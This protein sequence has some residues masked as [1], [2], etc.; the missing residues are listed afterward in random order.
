[1][2]VDHHRL[3]LR[4]NIQNARSADDGGGGIIGGIKRF[5]HFCRA[6]NGIRRQQHRSGFRQGDQKR[7][8]ARHMARRMKHPKASANVGIIGGGKVGPCGPLHRAALA[9]IERPWQAAF[10]R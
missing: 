3:G 6:R 5:G 2:A 8:L 7:Q 1:M 10:L 9:K 4:R